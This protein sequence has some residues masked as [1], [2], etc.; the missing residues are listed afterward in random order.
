MAMEFRLLGPLEVRQGGAEVAIAGGKPRA[1][2]AALLLSPGRV[3]PVDELTDLLWGSVPPPKSR[4]T[5]QNHVKRLRN[6]LGEAG[7]ERI[8]TRSPG[9]LI[10]VDAAEL[11]V[12]RFE[13]LLVAAR[14]AAREGAWA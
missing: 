9:Y 11:D 2:L 13:G 7:R 10:S 3:V 5:L 14:A 1:V 12:T 8:T 4:I 6:A